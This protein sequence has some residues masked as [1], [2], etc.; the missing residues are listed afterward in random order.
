MNRGDGGPVV[1]VGGSVVVVG[2][3]AGTGAGG[4]VGR[5]VAGGVVTRGARSSAR[6]ARAWSQRGHAVLSVVASRRI[7]TSV[8]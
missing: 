7:T 6:A 1:V 4:A 8:P 3:G 5:V 2:G